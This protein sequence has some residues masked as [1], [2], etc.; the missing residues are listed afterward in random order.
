MG[1]FSSPNLPTLKKSSSS[2][3]NKSQKSIV[4]FFQPKTSTSSQS[5]ASSQA[6]AAAAASKTSS[7]RGDRIASAKIIASSSSQSLTPAPSSDAINEPKS[8]EEPG[9]EQK[10]SNNRQGLPSPITPLSGIVAGPPISSDSKMELAFNSPS[11]KVWHFPE[12]AQAMLKF[13]YQ[14]KKAINY[15]ESGDEG[16]ED[17]EDAFNSSIAKPTKTKGRPLKRRRTVVDDDDF[18]HTSEEEIFHEGKRSFSGNG[19]HD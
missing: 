14:A 10:S 15:A 9:Y 6:N 2:Q 19:G 8:D 12:P 3:S 18:S 1:T 13:L 16:E 5:A 7:H 17:D 4:G 11:R